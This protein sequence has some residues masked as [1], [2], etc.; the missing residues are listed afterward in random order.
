[1]AHAR[2][3][4]ADAT[5]PYLQEHADNPVDWYP[6]GTEALARAR[7][8]DRPILLSIGYAACHWC[9][10]MA[11]ESFSDPDVAAVM[12]QH[13]VN[14]KVDREQR[15]DLDRIYQTA[16]QL[17]TGRG[18]G[19][20]LTVFL[21]PDDL[22]PFFAGTYFPRQAL[23]GLPALPDL[24]TRVATAYREQRETIREQNAQVATALA[25][26]NEA[27][28]APDTSLDASPLE[29]ARDHLAE[30]FDPHHGGFG[31]APKFP[32]PTLIQYL[33]EDYAGAP[34]ERRSSLHM[35][36]TTLRRMAL[37]GINDQV[38]GGFARYATDNEWMIPHFEKMLSDNALLMALY[39]D[40]WQATGDPLFAR[41][42]VETADWAMTEMRA[43]EG[44]FYSALDADSEGEEGRF[45]LWTPEAAQRLLTEAEYEVVSARFGLDEPAN[46]QGR[47]HFHV[48]ASISEL[49]K[50]LRTPAA[51]VRERLDSARHKLYA[52]RWQRT[53]PLQDNKVLTSWNALV[54]RGL[55]RTGR[56]LDRP[57]LIT[58]AEQALAFIRQSLWTGDRLLASWR[59]GRAELSAYLDDYA[60]LL[61]AVLELQ[62]CRWD[63]DREAF[64]TALAERLLEGFQDER[65]GGFLFTE[66]N[67]EELPTRSRP[68]ADDALP[69]GNGV[70]ARALI[71]LGHLMAE[72]HYRQAGE[73]AVASAAPALARLP[74][75]HA[76]LLSALAR[77][78]EPPRVVTLTGDPEAC[79]D[80]QQDLERYYR[81]ERLAII[82]ATANGDPVTARLC[83]GSHCLQPV[84]DREA[85][86]QQLGTPR[87]D[88]SGVG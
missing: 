24:L 66:H 6:W 21:T 7:D 15:P 52:E 29:Q 20:P 47:W 16:H 86:W 75:A 18:G 45:Y 19:W 8:E 27:P 65:S 42:A 81:P 5:S 60:F 48:Q 30:V 34:T 26:S 31:S 84:S 4:L 33:L 40:A 14:I 35:A 23:H 54:I 61:E 70:A 83:H 3:R 44:G 53:W 9:H 17:L 56:L 78:V 39:A 72:P 71:T 41:T 73:A 69:A 38:G 51:T 87:A 85:L 62:L 10:V 88:A 68:L 12:N 76:T 2:N 46:F 58:A 63:T 64:A 77:V 82:D 74:H 80:W 79:R 59:D 50:S 43:P 36:C 22:L 32:Q 49:A 67:H 25:R 55:A 1:M 11:R 13:F 28:G 57:D 37:G